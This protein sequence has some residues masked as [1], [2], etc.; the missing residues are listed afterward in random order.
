ML[1][2][3]PADVSVDGRGRWKERLCLLKRQTLFAREIVRGLWPTVTTSHFLTQLLS[4]LNG[5]ELALMINGRQDIDISEWRRHT[6]YNVYQSTSKVRRASVREWS[7][8]IR[9]SIQRTLK[10]KEV[11]LLLISFYSPAANCV[12]LEPRREHGLSRAS[13]PSILYHRHATVRYR[14]RG[15]VLKF[16]LCIAM[17][18]SARAEHG[19]RFSACLPADL[20]GCEACQAMRV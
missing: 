11:R 8:T 9:I 12:V 5:R 14:G 17:H 6:K 2:L 7:R 20:R 16:G 1:A 15:K 4:R 18:V 19:G 10:L 3:V 13:T